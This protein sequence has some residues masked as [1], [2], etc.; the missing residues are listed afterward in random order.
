MVGKS[1]DRFIRSYFNGVVDG[2]KA[3]KNGTSSE[4]VMLLGD[5]RTWD[6]RG[7]DIE[8]TEHRVLDGKRIGYEGPA[9]R[10]R[11]RIEAFG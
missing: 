4:R 10:Q 9:N 1:S 2:R 6:E 11:A 8:E 5:A 7:R 3:T